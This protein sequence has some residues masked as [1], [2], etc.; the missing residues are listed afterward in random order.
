MT[1][2][3]WNLR[4]EALSLAQILLVVCPA[5]TLFGYNQSGLGSLVSL[6]DWVKHFPAIDTVNTEGAEASHNA[7][8]QGVVIATFTLGALPGCLSCSYTADKFGRRP[9]I[10]MGGLLAL[11]GQVLEASSY[12]LAQMIVGRTVLGAGIGMLSGTVPTWQRECSSSKN[13][14]KHIVLDGLFIALGYM[15]QAWINVGFYQFKTGPVTW[16]AP[17][18]IP[19]V[20]AIVLLISIVFLPESPRWLVRQNRVAEARIYLLL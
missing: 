7:T 11:V 6:S 13:R 5:Y 19:I 2:R 1:S 10:F 18:A 8:I 15:L 16:R 3:F 9:V 14:G 12:Q 20:F 17:I 4:G